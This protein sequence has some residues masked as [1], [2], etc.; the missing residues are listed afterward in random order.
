M[1]THEWTRGAFVLSDDPSRLDLRAIHDYLAQS[2][3][4]RNIPFEIMERAIAHSAAFGLLHRTDAGDR[5]IGF[6]RVVTD[7]ATFGYL[8]DVYVLDAFRRQGLAEWMMRVV[9]AHEA[10]QGFRRWVLVTRDAHPLYA[11]IGYR[12]VAEPAT[13]MEWRRRRSYHE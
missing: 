7:Y 5:Q 4:S 8:A 2:Y 11:K 12:A 13:Y 1:T 3:W 10:L 9:H 6:C